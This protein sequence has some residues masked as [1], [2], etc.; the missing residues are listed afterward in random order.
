MNLYYV[1]FDICFTL[2]F[3]YYNLKYLIKYKLMSYNIL[4]YQKKSYISIFIGIA[5]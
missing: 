2:I 5:N 3:E 4:I 1:N